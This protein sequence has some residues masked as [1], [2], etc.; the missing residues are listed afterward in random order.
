MAMYAH[1][2]VL[3]K[4]IT[5]KIVRFNSI[6]SRMYV[7]IYIRYTYNIGP[8][9]CQ[10]GFCQNNGTCSV[11]DNIATCNCTSSYTGSNCQ[12]CILNL[13]FNF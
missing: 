13:K 10:P 9:S 11:V 1:V 7:Y 5:V 2:Q 8:S 6:K 4:A 12:T 3:V